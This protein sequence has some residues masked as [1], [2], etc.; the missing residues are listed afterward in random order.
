MAGAGSSTRLDGNPPMLESRLSLLAQSQG[1]DR[2]DLVQGPVKRHFV[3][4]ASADSRPVCREPNGPDDFSDP[5]SCVGRAMSG[6]WD[7]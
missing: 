2:L 7:R 5:L 4:A 3:A 1:K 6:P